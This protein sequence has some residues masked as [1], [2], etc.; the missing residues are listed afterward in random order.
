[1]VAN[2]PTAPGRARSSRRIVCAGAALAAC[3]WASRAFAGYQH[4]V[5]TPRADAR[6]GTPGRPRQALHALPPE[7]Y[8]ALPDSV[9]SI[10]NGLQ[11]FLDAVPQQVEAWGP[12]GPLYFLAV[13]V[14]AECIALPATPLTLSAGYLFGLPLGCAIS[15]TG[16]TIAACIGF[17]LARTL[18]KPQIQEL[19][20]ESELFQNINK[21]VERR[22]FKIILLLR[23]S[24][25]LPFSLSNYFYGL[26]NVAFQDYALATLLGF[27]PGTCG[28]VYFATQAK[29]LAEEGVSEP[30]YVYAVAAVV[31]IG[32]LKVVS[33]VARNA[34]DEAVA[35]DEAQKAAQKAQATFQLEHLFRLEPAKESVGSGAR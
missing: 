18:L 9:T 28:Y 30:W 11:A 20:Q 5:T 22:G 32:L 7:V 16:G 23:L 8:H 24:P 35:E 17:L 13:Y 19:A 26:S 31:T 2:R 21:A 14:A 3:L 33:D 25:L 6:H 4:K 1:M 12:L 29:L 15:L 34:V 10:A 27:A